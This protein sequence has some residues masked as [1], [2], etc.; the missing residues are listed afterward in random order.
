VAEA[1]T[2]IEEAAAV[3]GRSMDGVI[4]ALQRFREAAS[5]DVAGVIM[6][7]RCWRSLKAVREKL[8]AKRR[9]RARMRSRGYVAH[10][11]RRRRR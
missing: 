6:H 5:A 9:A 4:E 7:P 8:R 11:Q 2:R 3:S 1:L 10:G